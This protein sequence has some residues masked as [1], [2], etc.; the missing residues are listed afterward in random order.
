M[1]LPDF[2][3]LKYTSYPTHPNMAWTR[4]AKRG[5]IKDGGGAE[6]EVGGKRIAVFCKDG[7]YALDAMCV[8]QEQSIACGEIDGKVVEC[9][10]HFWHY[11]IETGELLDYLKDIRLQTYAAEERKDGIYIDI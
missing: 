11:N 8:H 6:F 3:V 1:D 7:F 5:S 4:V 9:P 10:H 2:T